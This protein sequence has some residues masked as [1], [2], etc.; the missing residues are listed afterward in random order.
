M[1]CFETASAAETP[2]RARGNLMILVLAL[3]CFV[4]GCAYQY[5]LGVPDQVAQIAGIDLSQV[6]LMMGVYG[7]CN[8]I[9]TPLLV[10]VLTSRGPKTLLLVSLALMAVGM[11]ICAATP[12]YPVILTGR[13]VMGVGNGTFAATAYIAASRIAGPSHAAS[14]MS[15]VA[16]GFSASFVF[17]L[18]AARML[19]NVITW[20]QAYWALVV[21]ACVAFAVIALV[22]RVPDAPSSSSAGQG[23]RN[24]DALRVF[25]NPCVVLPLICTVLMFVGYAS[26]NT[27]ITPFMESVLPQPEWVSGSLFAFGLMSMIGSKA[28]G[29]AADR[30]GSAS[31]VIGC[32]ALQAV[33]LVVLGL[34]TGSWPAAL[35]A[36]CMWTGISWG[37][38]PAQNSF[39]MLNAGDEAAFAVSLSN[40]SL[41]LGS[42]LGSFAA[43]VFITCMPLLAMPF[44]S[45]AFTACAVAAEIAA[46][47]LSRKPRRVQ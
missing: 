13:A 2:S 20:Q 18:P 1:S 37:F 31:A 7:V 8:A 36:A 19:R 38:L 30:F 41:Q 27:Y 35:A 16:L 23:R 21:A 43:G 33:T 44:V 42:A 24:A 34:V 11:A 46:L 39:I 5:I 47:R 12:I 17:A 32:V 6:S 9:G 29:W 25:R 15:N 4:F 10:M 22:V 3:S 45:A 40:S 26:M 28:S 14:A